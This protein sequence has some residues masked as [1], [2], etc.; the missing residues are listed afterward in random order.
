MSKNTNHNSDAVYNAHSDEYK[1]VKSDLIRLLILNAVIL[2]VVL[3]VYYT[4]RTSPYLENILGKL[5]K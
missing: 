4:D 3:T 1:M 2:G 5:L